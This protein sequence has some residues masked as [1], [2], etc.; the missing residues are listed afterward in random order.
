MVPGACRTWH[1][2]E[3]HEEHPIKKHALFPGHEENLRLFFNGKSAPI[4]FSSPQHM[5]S[6]QIRSNTNQTPFNLD[7][8]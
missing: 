3:C 6:F 7:R 4:H 1:R 5:H 8:V 2:N